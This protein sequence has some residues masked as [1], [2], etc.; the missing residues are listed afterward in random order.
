MYSIFGISGFLDASSTC[1]NQAFAGRTVL[2]T[3]L[4][5]SATGRKLEIDVS[6]TAESECHDVTDNPEWECSKAAAFTKWEAHFD[7]EIKAATTLKVVLDL[8]CTGPNMSS[9]GYPDPGIPALLPP[10][11]VYVYVVRYDADGQGVIQYRDDFSKLFVPIN[12]YCNDDNPVI[13]VEQLI[14]FDEPLN[15][16][17]V[18]TAVVIVSGAG[19]A[20]GNLGNLDD[21]PGLPVQLP[22]PPQDGELGIQTNTTTMTG[23]ISVVPAN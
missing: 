2:D 13:S 12:L 1:V 23:T 3:M 10:T 16:G 20:F 7:Y 15:A 8:S 19:G 21:L 14:E 5:H 18:D 11:D 6:A 4:N 22:P 17:D 9:P